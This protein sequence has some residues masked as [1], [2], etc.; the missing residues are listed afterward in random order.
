LFDTRGVGRRL[1]LA[2]LAAA[3]L[4]AAGAAAPLR[5]SQW[6]VWYDAPASFD[7]GGVTL[8]SP[9]STRPG[10]TF[11]TL[12]TSR[13]RWRDQTFALRMTTQRQLRTGSPANPWEVGWVMFR[14]LD[15]RN[16]YWFILKT[17]GFELGKKQG[18]FEQHFLVLGDLPFA[19]V[20]AARRVQVRTQGAR[21]RVWVDG[22]PIVDYVDAHPLREPGS[23]GLYEEDAR[24][25]FDSL[26]LRP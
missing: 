20:G 2:L 17:N 3:M 1:C 16:Y 9:G 11:S 18:S 26:S 8:W 4:P 19:P 15:R 12:V 7:R 25:R 22:A 10:E 5:A 23:I 13:A 6:T 24:V 21:I 14:F